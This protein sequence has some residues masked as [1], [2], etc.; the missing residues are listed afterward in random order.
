MH[1]VIGPTSA[2]KSTFISRLEERA[3]ESGRPLHV[4]LAH[5]L[6]EGSAMPAGADDVVH[7]NLLRGFRGPV[8]DQTRIAVNPLLD[9]LVTAAD[10]VTVLM[11]PRQ[12]LA[13]RAEARHEAAGAADADESSYSRSWL[14]TL[15]RS[16]LAQICEHLALH[17]DQADTTHRYLC[18]NV[19]VHGDYAELSRW[20]FPRL[21]GAD[22]EELCRRGHA[23]RDLQVSERTYQ[24]DY[25]PGATGSKRAATLSKA[26]QMPLAGKTLLDIG[27]AEG[28][29]ALS[30]AR[31]GAKVT[32]IEPKTRR[33]RQTRKI[34][35]ALETELDLRNMML[36][37]MD[38]GSDAF[39]VVLCFN[40][41]HHVPHPFAFLD[42]AADLA[43]SHLVLEYPG[44]QDHKFQAT[45]DQP[46]ALPEEQPLVGVSAPGADQTFVYTP[47]GL[48]QYFLVLTGIF[49]KH[50][51]F[52]SPI[53]DRWISIFS[54]KQAAPSP[55]GDLK[56]RKQLEASNAEAERLKR[57]VADIEASRSWRVTAPLRKVTGR[58][59]R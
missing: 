57:R 22:A 5:Q 38:E 59:H 35:A 37:G 3:V 11:A 55:Q 25:R 43:A 20:D 6:D 9:A 7:Y 28:A 56:L 24:A 27:C 13:T 41:I 4:H 42:R 47:A 48:E 32:A 36:D 46:R 39:D 58:L 21:A 54:D 8:D 40:V 26:L 50:E 1:L 17:L 12:V 31:M 49:G 51:H 45:L 16:T 14:R 19:E 33:F 44:L 52:P 23:E 10:E 18:T 2:G 30:A 53:P 29:A 15:R 34:A